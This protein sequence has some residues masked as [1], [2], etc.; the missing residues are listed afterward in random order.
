[1]RGKALFFKTI[2]VHQKYSRSEFKRVPNDLTVAQA[3]ENLK[4]QS[5]AQVSQ[6]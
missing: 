3:T 2:A 6:R 4:K 1:M 5:A